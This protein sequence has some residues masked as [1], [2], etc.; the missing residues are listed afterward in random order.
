[1]RRL[2]TNTPDAE[3]PSLPTI[4]QSFIPTLQHVPKG[5]R[6]RWAR[7]LYLQWW[8]IQLFLPLVQALYADEMCARKSICRSA[9]TLA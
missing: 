2:V 9:L 8:R 3:V 4:L 7:V 5:A 1:M 6:H